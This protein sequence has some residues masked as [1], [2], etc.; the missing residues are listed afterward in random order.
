MGE[1]LKNLL[2]VFLGLLMAVLFVVNL[3]LGLEGEGLS[4]LRRNFALGQEH[5]AADTGDDSQAAILPAKVA[6]RGPSGLY[7]AAGEGASELLGAVSP[8][9]SE[10]LGSVEEIHAV[11]EQ[12]FLD[13]L[14]GWGVSVGFT[15]DVPFS[16]LQHLWTGETGF[17]AEQAVTTLAVVSMEEQAALVFR[18]GGSGRCYL[19]QTAASYERL[20]DQCAAAPAANAFYAFEKDGYQMLAPCEAVWSEPVYYPVYQA[21]SPDFSAEGVVSEGLLSAF[22]INPFLAEVYKESNGDIIYI[23]GYVALRFGKD[24]LLHYSA[25]GGGGIDL[26][27]AEGLSERELRDAAA[28]QTHALLERVAAAAGCTGDFSVSGVESRGSGRY[29]IAFEQ[30]L[31]GGFVTDPDG[32]S[33]VVTVEQGRVTAIR[34]RLRSCTA[35]GQTMILPTA[36]AIS[37]LEG[38]EN[39][40]YVRYTEQNG[41]LTPGLY[42]MRGG[43]SDGME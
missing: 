8:I 33:A 20:Y 2:L 1:K 9:L 25:S 17:S 26:R 43:M 11:S 16:M 21:V 13:A 37:L 24:G 19:A 34:L 6:V 38:T 10:A 4:A 31:G 42:S 22:D 39:H 15:F 35:A 36:L 14:S 41:T 12:E 23:E 18:D 32:D 3:T 29:V 30:M 5:V 28:R 40:L 27:L 7:L